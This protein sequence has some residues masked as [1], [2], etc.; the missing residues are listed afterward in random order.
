MGNFIK[1]D[2]KILKWEWWSDINT[3]RLFFY[4]LVS[5]YWKDG[6]YKGVEIKRGSFPSSISELS[7]ETNLS[8]MEIR[9]ALKHLQSTGEVT[10]NQQANNKQDNTNLTS[11]LTE[12]QQ[13]TNTQLNNQITRSI[14]KEDKNIIS[15]EINNNIRSNSDDLNET[16]KPKKNK[17]KLTEEENEE[18]VKNFEIIYNSYP[19]KVGKA[20]GFK[21]YKQWLNGRNIDGT[22]IKLTNRQM[23][24]AIAKYKQYIEK[25]EMELQYIKQFD[26][27]MRNILD[28]VEDEQ[29]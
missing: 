19:K 21:V 11:N 15:K 13:A 8:T 23:W 4:M 17:P 20:S 22:K 27:F 1:I 24:Y 3:F 28:Y 26:T 10:T 18:L 25:E 14:L 2:R 6:N 7:R 5:A 16:D 12:N 29:Q 9:T